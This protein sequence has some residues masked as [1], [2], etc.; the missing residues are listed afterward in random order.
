MVDRP[1]SPR[2]IDII[3]HFSLVW[4][5]ARIKSRMSDAKG[6]FEEEGHAHR[7]IEWP[8]ARASPATQ[9]R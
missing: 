9:I 5:G 6:T 1:N 7:V 2:V 8:H 4:G 3:P